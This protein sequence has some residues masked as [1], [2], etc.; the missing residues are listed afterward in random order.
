MSQPAVSWTSR[1][2][3]GR[4]TSLSSSGLRTLAVGV[5]CVCWAALASAAKPPAGKARIVN[6]PQR[7]R[8]APSD[9]SQ[10]PDSDRYWYGGQTLLS[11]GIAIGLWLASAGVAG[12]SGSGAGAQP[13]GLLGTLTYIL[14]PPIIHFEH[15]QIGKGVASLALRLALPIAGI[16]VGYIAFSS[17]DGDD[18]DV[19]QAA[20]LSAGL[21]IFL[22][23]IVIDAA[24]LADAPLPVENARPSMTWSPTFT[25]VDG[26]PRFGLRG[27]F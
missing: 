22:S 5:G 24:L 15:Q 1:P 8:V 2:V 26:A 23:P 21:A 4:R 27:E 7:A 20:G 14:V 11:D 6:A 10:A 13:V 16:L 25:L 3:G 9:T 17:C 19:C 18:A 12:A